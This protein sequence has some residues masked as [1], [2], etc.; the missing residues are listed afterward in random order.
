MGQYLRFLWECLHKGYELGE[1]AFFTIET[2]CSLTGLGLLFYK[3]AKPDKWKHWEETV[4]KI[5]F[6]IFVSAFLVSTIFVAPFLQYHEAEESRI[7]AN[8]EISTLTETKMSISH[9]RDD[10]QRKQDRAD[11]MLGAFAL[12]Q[13]LT[14]AAFDEKLDHFLERFREMENQ[15]GSIEKMSKAKVVAQLE[16][17]IKSC[18]A[19][20]QVKVH[21][22][23]WESAS[24]FWDQGALLAFVADQKAILAMKD[25]RS[26]ARPVAKD[27]V[28]YEATVQ[29][30]PVDSQKDVSL[31]SLLNSQLLQ[32][33]VLSLPDP[34]DVVEGSAAVTINGLTMQFQIAQQRSIGRNLGVSGIRGIL[35]KEFNT[36]Q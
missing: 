10:L 26:Y 33:T 23:G 4:M 19:L 14:N 29:F 17:P 30:D 20:I 13:G 36:L 6:W 34:V 21:V 18:S 16:S 8:N 15:L 2:F 31:K 25:S 28:V 32:I 1:H 24:T 7:K 27:E 9:E 5:A 35:Q 12:T 3:K 11:A 22:A